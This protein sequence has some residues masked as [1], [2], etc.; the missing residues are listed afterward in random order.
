MKQKPNLIQSHLP[1]AIEQRLNTKPRSQYVSDA[2]LGGIDGC[3]TTFAVVSGAVGAGFSSTVALILGIAN[4][5]ADGFSMAASN[6]E[7]V[8]AQHEYVEEIRRTEEQHIDLIPEGEREEIRQIFERKG[9]SD[10]V[11]E[12]VVETITKDRHLW[13]NTMLTEEHGLSM[14]E[15]NPWRSAIATF[16]AFMLV[17]TIPLV[18]FL[19]QSLAMQQQYIYS[20]ILAGVMFFFVGMLKAVSFGKPI[21]LAGVTTLLT[22]GVAASLAF[23]SGYLLRRV[24]GI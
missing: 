5:I 8:K 14:Y 13:V 6:F 15:R 19:S 24:F 3:V 17:G 7:S 18:P 1:S 10:D 11:L 23:I 16:S 21:F 2:V 4:L 20:A 22:G 12:M 9:F